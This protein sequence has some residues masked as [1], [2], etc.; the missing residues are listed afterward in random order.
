MRH[1][2]SYSAPRLLLMSEPPLDREGLLRWIPTALTFLVI[3]FLGSLPQLLRDW[4][5]QTSWRQLLAFL[6]G[7]E[8]SASIW[9]LVANEVPWVHE[10]FG[11]IVV[12]GFLGALGGAPFVLRLMA[13]LEARLARYITRLGEQP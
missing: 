10:R 11:L 2:A 8:V 9:M 1:A 13:V 3:G 5:P 4:Q 6:M 7:C 12:A